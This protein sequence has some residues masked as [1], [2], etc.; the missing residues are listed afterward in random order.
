M[1]PTAPNLSKKPRKAAGRTRAKDPAVDVPEEA[2]FPSG[3]KGG[4]AAQLA[5][6]I[7]ATR[8]GEAFIYPADESLGTM[9][10]K[11]YREF[12]RQLQAKLA[13]YDISLAMWYFL[14]HL[15]ERDGLTQRELAARVGLMEGTTTDLI[16]RLEARGFVVRVRNRDD[17][18]KINVYLTRPA[19]LL[20]PKLVPLAFAVNES[21]TQGIAPEDYAVF[22]RVLRQ[23]RK[24]VSGD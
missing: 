7:G 14:R 10:R 9:L 4:T 19:R 23:I 2:P 18:R 1:S 13:E 22:Q 20:Q 12:G 3:V 5:Q 8:E 6:A 24:N 17:R 21:A 11:T 16:N 15:W